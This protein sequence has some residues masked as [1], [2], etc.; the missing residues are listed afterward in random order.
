M[1]V[2]ETRITWRAEPRPAEREQQA[3]GS[4]TTGCGLSALFIITFII[5]DLSRVELFNYI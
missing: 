3:R 2:Q 4:P 5:N 1:R